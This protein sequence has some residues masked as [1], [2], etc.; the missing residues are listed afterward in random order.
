MN[1]VKYALVFVISGLLAMCLMP[2]LIGPAI[3]LMAILTWMLPVF[4]AVLVAIL[5]IKLLRDQ[6]LTFN[7]EKK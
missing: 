3:L 7:K 5:L 4:I 1:I 6:N 2:V